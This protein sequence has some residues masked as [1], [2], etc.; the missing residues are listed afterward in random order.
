MDAKGSIRWALAAQAARLRREL[1]AVLRALRK[2]EG[3]GMAQHNAEMDRRT[4][5][6]RDADD[7][8]R[9]LRE[10]PG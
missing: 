10:P 7:L 8:L 2:Y 4:Q 1:D 5:A 3:D 9:Q 6:Q